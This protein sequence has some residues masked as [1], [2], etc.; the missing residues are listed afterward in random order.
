MNKKIL[1]LP[2]LFMLAACGEEGGKSPGTSSSFTPTEQDIIDKHSEITNLA[3]FEEFFENVQ[4]AKEDTI[5]I[6]AYTIEGDPIIKEVHFNGS[7]IEYTLDTTHDAF[8]QQAVSAT[9][10]QSVKKIETQEHIEYQIVGCENETDSVL[11]VVD[12]QHE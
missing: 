10:C 6:V 1:C 12:S 9:N 7:E 4:Q 11:L 5:R 8:G 3:R 2:M